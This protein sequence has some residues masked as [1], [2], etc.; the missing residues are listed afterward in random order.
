MVPQTY[1]LGQISKLPFLSS[2]LPQ[3]SYSV[4]DLVDRAFLLSD[5][6]FHQKNLKLIIGILINNGSPQHFIFNTI[7]KR[8]DT[9]IHKHSPINVDELTPIERQPKRFFTIPYVR[10][11]SEKFKAILD[12]DYYALSYRCFN[13]LNMFMRAHKDKIPY[14]AQNSV[15][16]KLECN[17]CDAS[18]VGETKNR[19]STRVKKH[20]RKPNVSLSNM[21]AV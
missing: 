2:D 8:I 14:D 5:P 15:V 20:R 10:G 6:M 7:N 18:Y 12:Q 3:N 19:L 1:L 17:N 4:Y 16:Y 21:I 11:V 9:L 13:R